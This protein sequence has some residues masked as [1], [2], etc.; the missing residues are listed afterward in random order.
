MWVG[1]LGGRDP[2]IAL[3]NVIFGQSP[4][5]QKNRRNRSQI[6]ARRPHHHRRPQPALHTLAEHEAARKHK[7]ETR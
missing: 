7:L 4:A 1:V 6:T 5:S 3:A 2:G